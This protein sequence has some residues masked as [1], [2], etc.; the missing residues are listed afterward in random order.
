MYIHTYI[1]VLSKH[2]FKTVSMNHSFNP[3]D[4]FPFKKWPVAHALVIYLSSLSSTPKSTPDHLPWNTT[5]HSTSNGQRYD[6]PKDDNHD[7]KPNAPVIYSKQ[8]SFVFLLLFSFE[9]LLA[10]VNF[11][12]TILKPTLGTSW[13]CGKVSSLYL[14]KT[15]SFGVIQLG[16]LTWNNFHK[17]PST[18]LTY[19]PLKMNS[20]N[21]K[22]TPIKRKLI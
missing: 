7:D 12:L 15:P 2:I 6:H 5:H 10:P 13:F 3:Q 1:H 21:L 18:R 19:I 11:R 9:K 17:K 16:L 4:L 22:I 8:G 14:S 20:W